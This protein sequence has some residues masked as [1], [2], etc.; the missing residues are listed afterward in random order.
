M[1]LYYPFYIFGTVSAHV[2]DHQVSIRMRILS[3]VSVLSVGLV[4]H[5]Y[6]LYLLYLR[7]YLRV[8]TGRLGKLSIS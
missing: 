2:T 1:F 5:M 3:L 6:L 7:V 4:Y 8:I